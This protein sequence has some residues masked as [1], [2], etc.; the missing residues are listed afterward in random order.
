MIRRRRIEATDRFAEK[1]STG[2]FS[3]WFPRRV[4]STRSAEH[5]GGLY[6]EKFTHCHRLYNSTLYYMRHR[7]NGKEGKKYCEQNKHYRNQ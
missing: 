7:L 5:A 4:R 1:C 2:I 6:K 3:H